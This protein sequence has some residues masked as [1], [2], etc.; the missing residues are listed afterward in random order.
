MLSSLKLNSLFTSK[1]VGLANSIDGCFAI[2]AVSGPGVDGY[3]EE[4]DWKEE[5]WNDGSVV[6]TN[7]DY[8]HLMMRGYANNTNGDEAL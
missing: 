7:M 3:G 1:H 4:I 2:F 5:G 8:W 6:E